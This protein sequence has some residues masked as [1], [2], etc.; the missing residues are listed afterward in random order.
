MTRSIS[1]I[2]AILLSLCATAQDEATNQGG[3]AKKEATYIPKDLDDAVREL[4]KFIQSEDKAQIRNGEI[5][6]I[7]MHFGLGV[8]LRNRWGLWGGSRLANYFTKNGIGHPDSMSGYILEAFVRDVRGKEYDLLE[9]MRDQA[10]EWPAF[11]AA[12]I[13]GDRIVEDRSQA[14]LYSRLDYDAEKRVV[15]TSLL[16][17]PDDG[18]AYLVKGNEDPRRASSEEIAKFLEDSEHALFSTTEFEIL[19]RLRALS[20]DQRLDLIRDLDEATRNKIDG[21]LPRSRDPWGLDK[22]ANIDPFATEAEQAGTGQPATR[23]E[24]KSEG[25]EKPQTESEGRSR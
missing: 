11:H 5:G 3:A 4:H 23:P 2:L 20:L 24:S 13:E 9:L 6:A 7:H 10:K 16:W 1:V 12:V 25:N 18:H 14:I 22:A 15:S 21:I 17:H 19:T 8:G